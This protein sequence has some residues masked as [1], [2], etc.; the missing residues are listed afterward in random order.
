M[1]SLLL[2]SEHQE[3]LQENE[4]GMSLPTRS[5]CGR[6]IFMIEYKS[7]RVEGASGA[8]ASAIAL[9]PAQN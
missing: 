1:I 2:H 6:G 5:G 9:Q 7:E 8:I 3:H 4:R